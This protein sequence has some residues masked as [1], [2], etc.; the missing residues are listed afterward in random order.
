MSNVVV[1][2]KFI[3]VSSS[4]MDVLDSVRLELTFLVSFGLLWLLCHIFRM[5]F[6]S[7]PASRK[8]KVVWT[9][10][11][12]SGRA[13]PKD[14]ASA[15]PA[16]AKARRRSAARLAG[17]NSSNSSEAILDLQNPTH[18]QLCDGAWVVAAMQ[19]LCRTQV[20]RSLEL[21]RDATRAG[22][23]V[24]AL[25]PPQSA[26]LFMGLVTSAIRLNQP[27]DAL[28]MLRECRQKSSGVNSALLAS[29]TRMCTS[30][31]FYKEC[32]E[33]YEFVAEDKSLVVDDRSVWSCL[34]F[35]AVEARE[36]RR[37]IDFFDKL[38]AFGAPSQK[39]YGNMIRYASTMGDWQMSLSLIHEMREASVEV[40]NVVYNTSLATC[41]SANEMDKA[42]ILLEEME[43]SEGIA[44]VITY[45][46]LAKG[47]AKMG[48]LKKCFE[49]FDH[50]KARRIVPS[51][52]TYG[53]LLDCCIND[54]Q[55]DKALEVFNNMKEQG[56][57]MNTVL[58]TT[59]IKGFA[60]VE[61]VD[62]AMEVYQ[63]MRSD[64]LHG[65]TPDVITFSI[66]IKAN[67]DAGRLEK[68]LGLL[69]GMME[70]HLCPDEVIFNNLLGGCIRDAN[71]ILA[72]RLYHSMVEGGIRPSNATFSILIRLFTSCRQ[73]DEAVEFLKTQ[74]AARRIV[75]EPRLYLQLTQACLRD[76]Q[77]RRA[78]EV[79]KL[80]LD[81]A[82]PT[83]VMTGSLL[84]TCVKLNMLATGVELL[85][86][87]A[88]AGAR[89]DWR[90]VE[91]LREASVKKKK[92]A[93][94]EEIASA[95]AK[96][97]FRGKRD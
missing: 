78:T 81:E 15:D 5:R 83:A 85:N 29:A 47:Y 95:M 53:I 23:D 36:F 84:S 10:G 28:K 80:M 33:I 91:G 22:L 64:D 25:T 14:S 24:G 18:E 52:V 48:Y 90:D 93:F 42:R 54:K 61:Q 30:K 69:D 4:V 17:G 32:L 66:L 65:V 50:M 77:G 62:R 41:V 34:I 31:Q 1:D 9:A 43:R 2:A 72:K 70:L 6:G 86:M 40:D 37:C 68:A 26:E 71:H 82:P 76:R 57:A 96:L 97:D 38:K 55:M 46:T 20:Q 19:H 13:A 92:D 45:N 49:L 16:P 67:C 27:R 79:F 3:G 8:P 89:V 58:Y 73:L 7:V 88:D 44:D 63:Q 59:L 35:C 87:A 75:P 12:R 74:P 94:A 51:Q 39:D 21:Y 11:P 60:R 56:C